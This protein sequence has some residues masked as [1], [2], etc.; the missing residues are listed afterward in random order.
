[1]NGQVANDV[2]VYLILGASG[3]IGSAVSRRLAASGATV[4]LASRPS[5]RLEGLAGELQALVVGQV[6][7]IVQ[8]RLA[9]RERH[10]CNAHPIM[11]EQVEAPEAERW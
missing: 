6:H 9:L 8:D 2:P 5:D 10:R 4:A 1:M 11:I 7:K 3:G